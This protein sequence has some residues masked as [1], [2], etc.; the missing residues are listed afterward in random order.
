[1]LLL[2]PLGT[3]GTSPDVTYLCCFCVREGSCLTA[4]QPPTLGEWIL[5]RASLLEPLTS[6]L[7]YPVTE[8][9]SQTQ[10]TYLPQRQL[11]IRMFQSLLG[12]AGLS[13]SEDV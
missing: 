7:K 10:V 1:M 9:G 4:V 13:S 3:E 2:L 5:P 6:Q 11:R 12:K 8:A